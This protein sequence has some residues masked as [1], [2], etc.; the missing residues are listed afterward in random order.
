MQEVVSPPLK[1]GLRAETGGIFVPRVFAFKTDHEGEGSGIKN[2][3]LRAP[4]SCTFGGKKDMASRNVEK[5]T[6]GATM[7]HL[8]SEETIQFALESSKISK[9]TR[10]VYRTLQVSNTFYLV[11]FDNWLGCRFN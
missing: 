1:R 8:W 3:L 6:S 4:K 7:P 9:E 2:K 10:E 5:F 11:H